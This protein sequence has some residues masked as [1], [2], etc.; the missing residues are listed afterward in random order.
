MQMVIDRQH[1]VQKVT[2]KFP[3]DSNH[4][5]VGY[6]FAGEE[7]AYRLI[8]LLHSFRHEA[9]PVLPFIAISSWGLQ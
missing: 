7:A 9:R 3:C 6:V 2:L 4:Y 5:A 1:A 8:M